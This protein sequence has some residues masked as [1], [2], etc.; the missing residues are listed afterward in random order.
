MLQNIRNNIQ[1]F[2]AKIIIG[3]MII[4]FALYGIDFLFNG[5][6]EVPVAV[7]NGEKVSEFELSQALALQKRQL[8]S[9]MGNNIDPSLLDD[10][11]LRKPALDS[12]VRQK[13]LLQAAD[14][15]GVAVPDPVLNS[16]IVKMPQFQVDGRFSPER[17]RQ[18]L[19]AQGFSTQLFK[20]LLRSDL[21]ID[22]LN[23]GISNSMFLTD[24]QRNT[25]I[26]LGDQKR[27]FHYLTLSTDY[28]ASQADI[29]QAE[30]EKYYQDNAAKFKSTESVRFAYLELKQSDFFKPVAEADVRVAY[31]RELDRINQ[32][33]ERHAAHILIEISD[34]RNREQAM[35]RLAEARTRIE[36][37]DSFEAVAKSLSDD[38]GSAE[39]GGELGYSAGETF[40]ESFETALAN[41]EPGQVSEPVETD[42]GLHLVKLLDVRKPE[43][44]DF[45]NRRATIEQRLQQQ[46]AK[47]KL[48]AEVEA[49]RDLVFNADGLGQPAEAL[50]LKVQETEWI[51]PLQREGL[52]AHNAV[53]KAA[54]DAELRKQGYNS[55]V[56]EISPEHYVVIHPRSHRAPELKPLADV[57]VQIVAE[58][59]IK[60]GRTLAKSVAAESVEALRGGKSAEAIA[61]GSEG[62]TWNVAVRAWRQD[63][64][65]KETIRREAFMLSRP[66]AGAAPAIATITDENAD[67]VV[68]QLT[69][70]NDGDNS[71]VGDKRRSE[72]LAGA[73]RVQSSQSFNAYFDSLIKT[74][75]I[76]Y[77]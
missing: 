54:F 60:K 25:A 46:A 77:N 70:V 16:S 42:A 1:G 64:A 43:L 19:S 40:P 13:V 23:N 10:A 27:S 35:Q 18:V 56:I 9:M 66:A 24:F 21:L 74:A 75:E 72:L 41:L 38:F 62:I 30:I 33:A 4:P 22:Q 11:I 52:M 44:P 5:S 63:P 36:A 53:R 68:V 28:F 12:L 67:Y 69:A 8:L 34:E 3:L 47:P 14:N 51:T 49:L 50:E 58:L 61:K 7:V 57:K 17:F 15:A 71:L 73:Q 65:V 48:I 31:Q 55:D 6:S 2:A 32:Q 45:D 59:R 29:E 26:R 37:G 76:K 39:Q 20:Q